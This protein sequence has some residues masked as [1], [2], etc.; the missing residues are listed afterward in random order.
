MPSNGL[1]GANWAVI[2]QALGPIVLPATLVKVTPGTRGADPTTGTNPTTTSHAARGFVESFE[3]RQI[4]GT[5]ITVRDRKVTLLADTI[6]GAVTPNASDRV[7]IEGSTYIV[8][9]ILER[10]P[11]GVTFILHCRVLAP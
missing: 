10:D 6:A 7:T 9:S 8:A 11:A 5:I 1:L 4:D 2:A 3:Q